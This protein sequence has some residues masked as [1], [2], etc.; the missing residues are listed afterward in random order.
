MI[1][2]ETLKK[3]S[4][5]GFL[6]DEDSDQVAMITDQVAWTKGD[7]IFTID[8]DAKYL[9]LLESGEVDLHYKVT[10]NLIS[11]KSKEFYIGAIN[12]GEVFGLSA[13]MESNIYTATSIAAEDS[14]AI[15]VDAVRLERLIQENPSLGLG[16]MTSVAKA[17]FERLGQVRSELVAAR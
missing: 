8:S 2:P 4:F 15:R 17:A 5:F 16:L 12:P 10:D 11:D 1:S 13:L 14:K 7:T 9:Y 3:Y 6:M